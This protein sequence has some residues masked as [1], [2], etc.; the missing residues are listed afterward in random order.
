M[1]EMSEPAHI[2]TQQE[3]LDVIFGITGGKPVD[4]FLDGLSL[5]A[6]NVQAAIDSIEQN[7]KD[8][9]EKL[10]SCQVSIQNG[11]SS[12]VVLD[13][14]SMDMSLKEIEGMVELSKDVL[15]HVASSIL[16]TTLIDSEAVQAYS[17]LLESIHVNIVEF[18]Q[19]YKDKQNF[20]NKIKYAL[21][22]QQQKKEL[23]LYK[24]NLEVEKLKL[25]NGPD[26][27]NA[28]AVQTRPWSQ[29]DVTKWLN[30]NDDDEKD[31]GQQDSN[32]SIISAQ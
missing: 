23:M 10:D 30:D 16:A 2:A 27:V 28:D 19:V 13:I 21:F 29:E 24:H 7:V 3:K 4:E 20:V 26:T 22:Q 32:A 1:Q 9:V 14:A 18:L 5:E 12:N 15:R 17:K 8:Q 25:K 6:G 11:Q 31:T